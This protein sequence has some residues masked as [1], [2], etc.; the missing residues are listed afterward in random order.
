MSERDG[1]SVE[2]S[3]SHLERAATLRAEIGSPDDRDRE[4]FGR[5][6]VALALAA[7]RALQR[8]DREVAASVLPRAAVLAKVGGDVDGALASVGRLAFH[9]GAWDQVVETLASVEDAPGTWN[10][11]GVALVRGGRDHDLERG[12]N[13]S[14]ASS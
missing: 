12:P 8:G 9:L 14:R 6:A 1:E 7:Q 3:A 11:L 4:L 2:V 10:M 5:A 13:A